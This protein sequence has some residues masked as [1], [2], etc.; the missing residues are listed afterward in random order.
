M[1]TLPLP[2]RTSPTV[3]GG[4]Y[5]LP[6][7]P[8]PRGFASLLVQPQNNHCSISEYDA[9]SPKQPLSLTWHFMDYLLWSKV[10]GDRKRKCTIYCY[11]LREFMGARA[12]QTQGRR[13]LSGESAN[14]RIIHFRH[15]F[16]FHSNIGDL[17]IIQRSRGQ[18]ISS[19]IGNRTSQRILPNLV[20]PCGI[21]VC[22]WLGPKGEGS[23]FLA[24][25]SSVWKE[26]YCTGYSQ[27]SLQFHPPL[28]R[29]LFSIFEAINVDFIHK[30]GKKNL[31]GW[32]NRYCCQ[33]C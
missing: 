3:T 5:I 19:T 28:P 6:L 4:W 26:N 10:P 14:S 15:L 12:I 25:T 31:K 13:L 20:N 23:L 21:N 8:T 11:R 29:S 16:T 2:S 22:G 9:P 33:Q 18:R 30:I 32:I 1:V 24:E 7:D 17:Y 27:S